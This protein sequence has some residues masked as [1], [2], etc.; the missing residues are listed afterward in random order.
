[1][2]DRFIRRPEVENITGLSRSTI[3]LY[4]S[5][6]D[7]PKPIKIG[8][9]AVAWQESVIQDWIASRV[10]ASDSNPTCKTPVSR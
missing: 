9:Q 4:I 7:F 1:M 5:R 2:T 8:I 6:G 10:A 3:Y